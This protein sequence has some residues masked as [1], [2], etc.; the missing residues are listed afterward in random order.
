MKNQKYS[1]GF[2]IILTLLTLCVVHVNGKIN[3]AGFLFEQTVSPSARIYPQKDVPALSTTDSVEVVFPDS[4]LEKAVR[5][6]LGIPVNPVFSTDMAG[7]TEFSAFGREIAVLTGL[8]YAVNMTHLSLNNNKIIDLTPLKDLTS[9]LN[10]NLDYNKITDISGLSGLVNLTFLNVGN[11]QLTNINGIQNLTELTY[12]GLYWNSIVDISPLQNLTKLTELALYG[13]SIN[14]ISPIKNLV[15]LIS[16]NLFNNQISHLAP[17]ANLPVLGQLN[18]SSNNLSDISDLT[19]LVNL[20]IIYLANNNL[21]DLSVLKNLPNLSSV[22]F[23]FNRISDISVCKDLQY[24]YIFVGNNNRISDLSALRD[25]KRLGQINVDFNLLDNGDLSDLY[26]HDELAELRLRGNPGVTSGSAVQQLGDN[27]LK[28]T[29]QDIQWDGTCGKDSSLAVIVWTSPRD[30]AY[31]NKTVTVQATATDKNQ[32]KVQMNIDWGDG[33]MSGY[34]ELK[35][36]G[37]TF[38]FTHVY[39]ITGTYEIKVISKNE[40]GVETSW[41]QS[42]WLPVVESPSSVRQVAAVA[43]S[44]HLYQNYP[45][46]FNPVT[47]IFYQLDRPAEVQ[48]SIYNTLGQIMTILVQQTQAE[49]E[50]ICNWNAKDFPSGIYFACLKADQVVLMNKMILMR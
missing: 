28:M 36:N 35:D 10:L 29:C 12:L 5:E 8:E 30:T 11:N 7:L 1:S 21:S 45:N 3:D 31:V 16:I 44:F 49:G 43:H 38:Q 34:S 42:I 6:A 33:Q 32:S 13:N 4:M 48:V 27:L 23:G 50:Y 17:L 24:L 2:L 20:H 14:D 40:Q 15:N 26:N 9:L 39:P 37:A 25:L 47:T 22:Y 18:L 19:N 46:P 41:S